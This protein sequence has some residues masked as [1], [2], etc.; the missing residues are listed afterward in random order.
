MKARMTG[1]KNRYTTHE[2]L[3]KLDDKQLK[4]PKHDELVLQLLNK[5]NTV[6]LLKQL[7]AD[8][9]EIEGSYL[10]NNPILENR[11]C[12]KPVNL[13]NETLVETLQNKVSTSKN[14]SDVIINNS[15]EPGLNKAIREFESFK[16]NYQQEASRL[17]ND[18]DKNTQ[19][20][21]L[22]SEVP[23][24]NGSNRFIIGYIDVQIT[25]QRYNKELLKVMKFETDF[26]VE[27]QNPVENKRF[28]WEKEEDFA[29]RNIKIS[30]LKEAGVAILKYL[31]ILID[32][33]TAGHIGPC[34]TGSINIEVKPKIESFGETLRQLNTYREYLPQD[35]FIIYSPDA[36]FKEAFATQGISLIT[37]EDI[38]L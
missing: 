16:N 18:Y 15:L 33:E 4:T 24:T 22:K 31:P 26:E 30:Y 38:G 1:E 28:S 9:Y 3:W 37:P 27:V 25:V 29:P 19:I 23:I 20:L 5:K 21:E 10:E 2:Q 12:W 6:K 13:T 14:Y 32:R 11:Y 7:G 35:V 36:G 34:D 17:I 8:K